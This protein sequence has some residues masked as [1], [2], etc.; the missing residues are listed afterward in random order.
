MAI[1]KKAEHL[2]FVFPLTC[3][4][5]HA[6]PSSLTLQARNRRCRRSPPQLSNTSRQWG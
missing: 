1:L 2:D 6:R 4:S 3:I 5:V